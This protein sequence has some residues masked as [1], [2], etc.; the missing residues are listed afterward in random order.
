MLTKHLVPKNEKNYVAR[1]RKPHKESIIIGKR[2]PGDL[3]ELAS[4]IQRADT[5]TN[6]N[7]CNKLQVIAQQ[8]RFLQ[9]QAESVLR[10]TKL[11]Q[12]L[13]HVAC[14]FIK[15]PGNVY[16]LYKK[17]DEQR[18]FSM[19]SL[20]EWTNCP[21]Q[22]LGSFRLELDH[23]WTPIQCIDQKDAELTLVNKILGEN[24]QNLNLFALQS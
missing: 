10:E 23:S 17:P 12:E 18:Y 24:D 14:N 2:T 7:A 8:I 6:A 4:E 21:H 11:N 22:Y 20:Q 13:H 1:N 5:F 19:L 3:I 9:Q 16:H 15:V